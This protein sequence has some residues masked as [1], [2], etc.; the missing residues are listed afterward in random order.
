M[1]TRVKPFLARTSDSATTEI[2]IDNLVLAITAGAGIGVNYGT[3]TVVNPLAIAAKASP[4]T[5]TATNK[6][7]GVVGNATAIAETLADGS[8]ASG[9]L[10]LTGGVDGTVGVAREI[11]VDASNIYIC[12]ATNTIADTNWKKSA[13]VT[14]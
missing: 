8:W 11:V 9:A 14:L 1:K 7:K 2:S 5:M 4:S 12:T 13:L 6:I 3:G 10:F